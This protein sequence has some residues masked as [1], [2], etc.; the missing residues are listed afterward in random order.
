MQ[1]AILC[2]D[3]F[4]SAHIRTTQ[5]TQVQ[6]IYR[7]VLQHAVEMVLVRHDHRERE[8]VILKR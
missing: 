5:Q 6:Y 7:F 2:V 1:A 8:R 4:I 3:T